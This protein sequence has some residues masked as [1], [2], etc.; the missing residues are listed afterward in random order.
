MSSWNSGALE[1]MQD[2]RGKV[3]MRYGGGVF[4]DW[5]VSCIGTL[6][7]SG[8]ETDVERPSL[9]FPKATLAAVTCCCPGL[10][11]SASKVPFAMLQASDYI[12]TE[13]D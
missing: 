5:A 13:R 4:L 2:S 3:E 12:R 7:S 10:T 9:H 11:H 1:E 6:G 8:G